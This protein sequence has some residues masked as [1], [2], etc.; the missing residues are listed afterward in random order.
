MK[1]IR[2]VRFAGMIMSARFHYGLQLCCR[3][4]RINHVYFVEV[5]NSGIGGRGCQ[6]YSEYDL[7]FPI[8]CIKVLNENRISIEAYVTLLHTWKK[9]YC[10][11]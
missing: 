7:S 5:L 2:V 1:K 6:S 8:Y 11:I 4:Y 3:I 9:Y 10:S